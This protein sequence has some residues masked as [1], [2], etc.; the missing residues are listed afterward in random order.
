MVVLLYPG[1]YLSYLSVGEYSPL[2]ICLLSFALIA[3]WALFP[4]HSS[5]IYHVSLTAL[6]N[7]KWSKY[8]LEARLWAPVK[9]WFLYSFM[10]WFNKVRIVEIISIGFRLVIWEVIFFSSECSCPCVYCCAKAVFIAIVVLIIVKGTTYAMISKPAI[11][12]NL[13][14]ILVILRICSFFSSSFV[15]RL[16]N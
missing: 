3:L 8:A 10:V 11:E 15:L 14:I 7:S 6:M 4:Y 5:T 13:M 2:L 1:L 12:K 9:F 16:P